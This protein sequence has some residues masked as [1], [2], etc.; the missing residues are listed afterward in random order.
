ME[1]DPLTHEVASVEEAVEMANHFKDQG[2]FN[3][4]RGQAEDFPPRSSLYRIAAKKDDAGQAIAERRMAMFSRWIDDIPELHYLKEPDHVNDLFAIMQHYGIPTNYLDFTTDPAVAGFFAADTKNPPT[5]NRSCI[6]CLNSDDLM[7]VWDAIKDVDERKGAQLETVTVDVRN[8]WRLQAQRGVFLFSNYDWNLDYTVVRIV[9][10]Y[11]GYPS[12]PTKDIIYPDHKSPLEQLLDQYFAIENTTFWNEDL[13]IMIEKIQARGGNAAF[14][15]WR[16]FPGGFYE[17]AFTS[18]PAVLESWSALTLQKWETVAPAEKFDETVGLA[19]KLKLNP[20][21]EANEIR[22]SVSFAV[23]QIL[24]S[25]RT[26]RTKAVNWSLDQAPPSLSQEKFNDAVRPL[27]NGMRRLPYADSELA[28]ACGSAAALV[29]VG[30][31]EALYHGKEASL[32]SQCFGE[33]LRI[34]FA[35]EDSSGSGGYVT[36][37]ALK[38]ALRPDM[39]ELLADKFKPMAGDCAELFKVIY[40]PRRMFDFDSFKGIFAREVIPAQAVAGRKP[41]LFN[42]ARLITFGLP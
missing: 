29:A 19:K 30:F 36:L 39:S 35:N 34:G 8:L 6:Y 32:F 11:T 12:Y 33:C 5:T 13:K 20:S 10:P 25:D 9:F 16:T 28:D 24:R 3:W 23:S 2:R 22:K 27:W 42:P 14:T 4:F 21:A 31:G 1:R 15:T 7:A 40:N 41:I 17:E 38:K 37:E 26:I 18:P